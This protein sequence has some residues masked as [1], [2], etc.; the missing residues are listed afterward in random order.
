MSLKEKVLENI[1]EAINLKFKDPIVLTFF[2]SFLIVNWDLV[3]MAVSVDKAYQLRIDDIKSSLSFFENVS[4]SGF[5]EANWRS[6]LWKTKGWHSLRY[7]I[8]VFLTYFFLWEWPEIMKNHLKTVLQ[9]KVDSINLSIEANKLRKDIHDH[10]QE[11]I[12]ELK[13]DHAIKSKI[14]KGV[15]VDKENRISHLESEISKKDKQ[16]GGFETEKNEL[17]I[18]LKA[19]SK[20]KGNKNDDLSRNEKLNLS[21]YD[22]ADHYKITPRKARDVYYDEGEAIITYLLDHFPSSEDIDMLHH[23]YVGTFSTDA[24]P[25]SNWSY[26]NFSEH[27]ND[28]LHCNKNLDRND[29]LRN[30]I[31]AKLGE[32]D[33]LIREIEIFDSN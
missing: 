3:L 8:P 1:E 13:D 5:T 19:L 33:T 23:F 21:I 26:E 22:F 7:I 14:D 30:R 29:G 11:E 2:I 24:T 20:Q 16:I 25:D 17:E 18:K 9:K 10:Y 28:F 31:E 12:K 4:F 15:L 6:E 32:L 27:I